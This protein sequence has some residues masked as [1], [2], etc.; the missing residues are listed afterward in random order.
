MMRR[1]LF[2]AFASVC[3]SASA[4]DQFGSVFSQINVV[5]QQ[6]SKAYSTLKDASSTIGHRLTGSVNGA[7]AETYAYNLLKSYGCDVKYQPFEVESWDRKTISVKVGP[8]ANDQSP[9]KAVTLAHSPVSA[10]VTGE[11]ID[12]GNGLEV[13]YQ[14]LKD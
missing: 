13:D 14:S 7:K 10:N 1:F 9:I 5:V 4:Q 12:V 3:I 6:N 11:I 8:S 2:L